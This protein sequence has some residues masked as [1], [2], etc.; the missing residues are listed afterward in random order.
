M[1]DKK[2]NREKLL[3]GY[4]GFIHKYTGLEIRVPFKFFEIIVTLNI[5][6][7]HRFVTY[8][9]NNRTIPY[10]FISFVQTSFIQL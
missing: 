4:T 5:V 10:C 2:G 8:S 6:L 3:S 9:S 7:M 1:N